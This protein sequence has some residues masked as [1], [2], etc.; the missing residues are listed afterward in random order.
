[1]IPV[2]KFNMEIINTCW[3]PATI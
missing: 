3:K 1:M 2:L